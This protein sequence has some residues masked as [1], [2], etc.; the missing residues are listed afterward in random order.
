MEQPVATPAAAPAPAA[1][2]PGQPLDLKQ[3]KSMLNL[4]DTATDVE[5]ITA[6]VELISNLQ[7]KY[8]ALLSDAVTL[9]DKVANRDIE[10]FADVIIPTDAAKEF[11]KH[12]I[13]T[14]RE[15]AV[16]ILEGMRGARK[17]EQPPAPAAAKLE[18]RSREPLRNRLIDQPKSIAELSGGAP[19]ISTARAVAIR[20][21]AHELRKNEKLPWGDAFARAEKEIEK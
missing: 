4:P 16:A 21:R 19:P 15:Q 12:Q 18:E 14:N 3:I 17:P 9:E 13:L 2:A 20:N 1:A 10:D 8:D 5:L 11:W 7:Q 6:L